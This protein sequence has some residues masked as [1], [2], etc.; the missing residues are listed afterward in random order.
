[1]R[2]DHLSGVCGVAYAKT[3]KVGSVLIKQHKLWSMHA[4]SNRAV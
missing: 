3:I 1:M 4:E 2:N